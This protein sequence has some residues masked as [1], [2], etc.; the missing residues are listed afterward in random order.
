MNGFLPLTVKNSIRC[1][2]G[3][4]AG[5][6]AGGD[7]VENL[8][9]FDGVFASGGLARKHHC[10]GLFESGVCDVGDLCSRG[11]GVDDHR[12][13]HV[14]GHDDRAAHFDAALHDAP[15]DDGQIFH[16]AFD[17]EIPS[18]DH[19]GIGLAD[20]LVEVAHSELVFDFRDDGGLASV[21]FEHVAQDIDVLAFAAEG[22]CDEVH[23]EFASEGY[24]GE[25]FFGEGRQI[26]ADAWQIDVAARAHGALGKYLTQD[27]VP[28]FFEDL[29]VDHAVID[30]NGIALGDVV[31]KAV[32]IHID[33]VIFLTAIAFDGEL[34]FVAG[35]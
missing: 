8:D 23:S 14:G 17:P 18:G 5:L 6:D 19:H 13:E 12:L 16:R 22:E 24:V 33:R 34:E 28:V 30:Q 3:A 21:A 25:V 35:L 4:A 15:L 32:V 20:D 29:H 26:Y 7:A 10:V 27:A 2:L 11:D 1:E 9:A 31:D